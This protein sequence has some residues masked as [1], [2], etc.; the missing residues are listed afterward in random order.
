MPTMENQIV[1]FVQRPGLKDPYP[2]R[3]RASPV[4][5]PRLLSVH[6][7]LYFHCSPSYRC[8]CNADASPCSVPTLRQRAA[9]R[10]GVTNSMFERPRWPQSGPRGPIYSPLQSLFSSSGWQLSRTEDAAPH[11]SIEWLTTT[12]TADP[13]V[14]LAAVRWLLASHAPP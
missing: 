14:L 4:P 10:A 7:D 9:E 13:A 3:S 1:F 6:P 5:R 2:A 12:R 11:W 8:R